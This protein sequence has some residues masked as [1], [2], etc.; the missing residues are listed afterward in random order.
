MASIEQLQDA[1]SISTVVDSSGQLTA[2]ISG[3]D[4]SGNIGVTTIN[5]LSDVD[6]V[7]E[8]TRDGSVLVYKSTTNRWTSTINLNAQNMEGGEF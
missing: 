7:T 8:G 3:A 5:E 2:V 1:N 6:V 4:G